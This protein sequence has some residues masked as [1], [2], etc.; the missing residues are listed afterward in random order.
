MCQ[1]TTGYEIAMTQPIIYGLKNCDSCRKA[2]KW[3]DA[4]DIAHHFVDYRD[5][6][7]AATTLKFWAAAVDGWDQLI[8]RRS[9]TWRQLS[10]AERDTKGAVAWLKL[11]AKH[12]TLIKRPVLADGKMIQV[13]FSEQA[14]RAHFG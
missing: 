11:V 7:L 1:S 4:H 3:L 10:E 14:Y 9:T 8:N 12:P 5:E 13:G 2:C 6:P